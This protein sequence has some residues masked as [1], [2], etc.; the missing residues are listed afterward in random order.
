M[1]DTGTVM[2]S[3]VFHGW[4]DSG[5][6]LVGGK[7]YAYKA[8]TT[9]PFDTYTD[10]DLATPNA[11]PVILDSRGQATVYLSADSYKFIL[12]TSADALVWSRDNV[13]ST[14]LTQSLLSDTIDLL[15]SAEIAADDTAYPTGTTFD[16]L[17]AGCKVVPLDSATLTGTYKFRAMLKTSS[18]TVTAALVNLSDGTP[19]VAVT[20]GECSSTSTTGTAATSSAI[21]TFPSGGTSKDYGV[22]LKVSGAG[23]YG[24]AW[25]CEIIRVT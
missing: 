25:G 11:N 24:Q 15:G 3:P 14:Q 21:I 20:G 6:P 19:N 10:S 18:G 4:D 5:D 9:T 22:K 13:L 16:K 12:H 2:P 1:A 8:G 7:L 23:V 17:V